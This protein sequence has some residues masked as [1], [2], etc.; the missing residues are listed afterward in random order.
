[1]TS[2]LEEHQYGMRA[3]GRGRP[4]IDAHGDVI[5]A[6]APDP[7]QGSAA[8]VDTPPGRKAHPANFLLPATKRW[9]QALPRPAR[10]YQLALYYPRLANG[11]AVAWP[12]APSISLLFDHLLAARSPPRRGFAPQVMAD[13]TALWDQWSLCPATA[14]R[15]GFGTGS[16]EDTFAS[17][18][19]R[20]GKLKVPQ[21][22][23]VRAA[24][25]LG[26]TGPRTVG[27]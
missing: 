1:M 27:G 26:G 20:R 7:T 11:F 4:D 8:P 9:L 13:I 3:A 15:S 21:W 17:R 5:I 14:T 19:A 18:P 24:L 2:P 10:P 12:D 23:P 22:R 25:A 16:Q 6:P